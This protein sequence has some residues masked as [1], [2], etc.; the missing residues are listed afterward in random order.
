MK[1]VTMSKTLI[2]NL[3]LKN[4]VMKK[5]II[6]VFFLLP[7]AV[8]AQQNSGVDFIEGMS[9]QQV[10]SK[11]K[12]ENKFIFVDM[13]ATWCGPCKMMDKFTYPKQE[14][15]SALRD[16][17]ISVKVQVDSTGKDNENVKSWYRDARYLERTYNVTALPTFLF[18]SPDGKI[19]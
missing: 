1:D 18:F 12:E 6:P 19:V 10:L 2:R 17:F 7:F 16:K 3:I 8:Q 5:F 15:G 14:V 4:I 13:V 9:W 11:A